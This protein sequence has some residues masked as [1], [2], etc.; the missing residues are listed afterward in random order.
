MQKTVCG[1]TAPTGHLLWMGSRFLFADLPCLLTILDG[2]NILDA[3][4]NFRLF[5]CVH[6]R[7]NVLKPAIFAFLETL[8]ILAVS[9][10]HCK[11][12]F[13]TNDFHLH[14]SFVNKNP[15]FR[16]AWRR[17]QKAWICVL[18]RYSVTADKTPP[19]TLSTQILY[20]IPTQK[21]RG[22]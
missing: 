13:R 8:V 18:I 12:R 4:H 20:H 9:D 21:S 6:F 16:P 11:F 19:N 17:L 15:R 22:N 1:I 3:G 5:D 10:Q 14:F 7:A 2:T